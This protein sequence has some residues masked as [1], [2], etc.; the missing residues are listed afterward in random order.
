VPEYLGVEAPGDQDWRWTDHRK[1]MFAATVAVL[2]AV[3]PGIA[4]PFRCIA[5]AAALGTLIWLA[6][7]VPRWTSNQ[8]KPIKTTG[9]VVASILAAAFVGWMW[10]TL[11][12]PPPANQPQ[13]TAK[14]TYLDLNDD[15][16]H[17]AV[18]AFALVELTNLGDARAFNQWR[19][20]MTLNSRE[21]VYGE[22]R[23]GILTVLARE[24]T[25]RC[26][27]SD[28][29]EAKAQMGLG[30]GNTEVGYMYVLFHGHKKLELIPTSFEVSFDDVYGNH[31]TSKPV[32][33]NVD[34]LSYEP[35]LCNWDDASPASL[36]K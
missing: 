36:S 17:H 21:R 15:P 16:K 12:P 9:V 14:V 18:V 33:G 25:L 27:Y 13:A 6:F 4:V 3:L 19:A 30:K 8:P 35:H 34:K 22:L 5:A 24:F 28:G 26:R 11:T 23:V 31:F 1:Q 7:T 20:Y 29:I 10:R 2:L 32:S